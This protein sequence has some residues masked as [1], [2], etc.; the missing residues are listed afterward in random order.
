MTIRQSSANFSET[1][2]TGRSERRPEK[3]RIRQHPDH[4]D[5]DSAAV[6]NGATVVNI[7]EVACRSASDGIADQSLG[8]AVHYAATVKN[9]VV[10]AAAGNF[11]SGGCMAQNPGADPLDPGADPWDSVATIAT[12]AWYDDYVLTVGSVDPDGAASEF[13]LGARGGT[14]RRPA[15]ASSR[16]HPTA[17]ARRAVVQQSRAAD[18]LRRNQFRGASC[19]RRWHSC[20]PGIRN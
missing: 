2:R 15:P 7:S 5:G 11:R 9:A 19:P 13:T 16:S 14:W 17:P 1:R 12:P 6:D 3:H 10:V 4:G 18:A 20:A 8:A